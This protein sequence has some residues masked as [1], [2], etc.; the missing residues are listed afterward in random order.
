MTIKN[1]KNLG[2]NPVQVTLAPGE[3]NNNLQTN[4]PRQKLPCSYYLG[5][6]EQTH[7]RPV[8]NGDRAQFEVTNQ[9]SEQ[10]LI[11]VSQ[12]AADGS[13]PAYTLFTLSPGYFYKLVAQIFVDG[14]S[15]QD[16]KFAWYKN[17]DVNP[18]T[19][20]SDANILGKNGTFA[21][22]ATTNVYVYTPA[23]AFL[24][25]SNSVEEEKIVLAFKNDDTHHRPINNSTVEITNITN[26]S[27]PLV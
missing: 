26:K 2:A 11:K 9:I 25:F 3:F 20:P 16:F 4:I 19:A 15:I 22:I 1:F 13:I 27:G 14:G 12:I 7:S 23:V 21:H 18:G 8:S 5:S 10:K 6:I 24:D 17:S